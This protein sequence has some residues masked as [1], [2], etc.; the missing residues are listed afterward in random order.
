MSTALQALERM[1][2]SQ[3]RREQS[4]VDESLQMMQLAQT[5]AYQQ[6]SLKQS[7]D[8]Q[9]ASLAL[10]KRR[11]D[12]GVMSQNLELIGKRNV[13]LQYDA[14]LTLAN[15]TQ[16]PGLYA[17][18]KE[19][20]N[21]M[22]EAVNSLIAKEGWISDTDGISK[23]LAI[24]LVA[25]TWSLYGDAK[26]PKAMI[27]IG[28]RLHYLGDKDNIKNIKI[29]KED[30][31]LIKDFEMLGIL[32][33]GDENLRSINLFK[34][35]R[36]TLDTD[37]K[38]GK[39]LSEFVLGGEKAYTIETEFDLIDQ[40]LK[41]LDRKR[42]PPPLPPKDD[43]AMLPPDKVIER[44]KNESEEL[45]SEKKDI[46]VAL[47]SLA[48]LERDAEFYRNTGQKIP[49]KDLLALENKDNVFDELQKDLNKVNKDLLELANITKKGKLINEYGIE[50]YSKIKDYVAPEVEEEKFPGSTGISPGFGF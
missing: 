13:K 3:E 25:A 6:A 4:R 35:M 34:S 31:Q 46:E 29:P 16:L 14:A 15:K 37:E 43:D 45:L 36:Q 40:S 23:E 39:E 12:I 20:D 18:Y 32:E 24:D 42:T 44:F 26:D 49:E 41:D 30:K 22:T 21:G 10:Q 38:V 7:S 19:S 5:A 1:L 50:E 48:D 9:H 27:R 8:Y 28:S 11:E 2:L 17:K 33:K 47:K